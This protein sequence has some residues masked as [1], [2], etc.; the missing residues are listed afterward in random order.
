[1][2]VD[3]SMPSIASRNIRFFKIFIKSFG[4]VDWAD[5]GVAASTILSLDGYCFKP[6]VP[7]RFN[8][9]PFGLVAVTVPLMIAL[10][11]LKESG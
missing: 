1:M 3:A 5:A 8:G 10:N 6:P 11:S 2:A 9:N 4:V 7:H